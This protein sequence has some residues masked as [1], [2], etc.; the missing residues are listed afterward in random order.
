MQAF[1]NNPSLL[2]KGF[3]KCRYFN[4]Y[5]H[6]RYRFEPT[7]LKDARTSGK[8]DFCHLKPPVFKYTRQLPQPLWV[9]FF[10]VEAG[11]QW[12]LQLVLA[13]GVPYSTQLV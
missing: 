11:W 5:R 6:P 8:P 2:V 10:I 9:F 7:G 12:F 3:S 1:W 4:R 13:R